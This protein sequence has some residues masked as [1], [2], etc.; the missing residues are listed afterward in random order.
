MKYK[1]ICFQEETGEKNNIPHLQ[2]V[3]QFDELVSF[4]TLKKFHNKI[5]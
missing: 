5:H 3:V 1:K 2:G 4:S